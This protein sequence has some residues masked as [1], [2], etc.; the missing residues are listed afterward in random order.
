MAAT[1]LSE[2]R[3]TARGGESPL[4]GVCVCPLQP[5]QPSGIGDGALKPKQPQLE[6][7][8]KPLLRPFPPPPVSPFV[9]PSSPLPAGEEGAGTTSSLAQR[10]DGVTCEGQEVGTGRVFRVCAGPLSGSLAEGRPRSRRDRA[11]PRP[12]GSAQSCLRLVRRLIFMTCRGRKG[13]AA[14]PRWASPESNC[15]QASG[16][17][18][19]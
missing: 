3:G 15:G 8:T 14:L 16:R 5:D 2:V 1:V 6:S 4:V 17:L 9:W 18:L 12:L 10:E 19:D 7:H 11:V 13:T